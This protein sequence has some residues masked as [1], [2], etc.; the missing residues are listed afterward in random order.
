MSRIKANHTG[1]S[2]IE[3]LTQTAQVE[4]ALFE[5]TYLFYQQRQHIKEN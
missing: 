4:P 5:S 2:A 3:T 1:F